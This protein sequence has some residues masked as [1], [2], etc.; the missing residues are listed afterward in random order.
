MKTYLMNFNVTESEREEIRLMAKQRYM[1]V[2]GLIK[3]S[4]KIAK[5]NTNKLGSK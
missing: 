3:Y 5:D 4:L 2:S 1:T